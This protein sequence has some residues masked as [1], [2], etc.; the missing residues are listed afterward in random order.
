MTKLQCLVVDDERL[1]LEVMESYIERVP[2]LHLAKLCLTPL[3]ALEF[4]A[5]NPVDVLFLDI[6]MPGLTGLQLLQT[7]K[8]PPPL[9]VLTTAY[10]QF[11]VEAFALDVT[12][13]LLKPIPF[14]RFLAA[15]QKVQT[16]L[17]ANRLPTN[18]STLEPKPLT[19]Q[20]FI[21]SGVKTIRVDLDDILYIEGK[22]DYV[23]VHTRQTKIS[24]QFSLT[25]FMEKLPTD[26]FARIHRSFIVALTKVDSIER[27]RI[28]IGTIE[29]PIGELYREDFF[30]RI[31]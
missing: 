21:K 4:I 19:G 7:L 28:L 18:E 15:V 8:A 11:A 20:L 13:Y 9:V 25:S 24:T 2:F 3:Q 6:D 29:V 12:D 31:G 27:N 10:S 1:A 26:Q 16:Q 17:G 23:L 14:S 30:K 5:R 22:K